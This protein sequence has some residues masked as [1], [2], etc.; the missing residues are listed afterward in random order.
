MRMN[1]LFS[2]QRFGWL[3]N[4]HTKE[5]YK[6][7]LISLAVMVAVL[8]LILIYMVPVNR[9]GGK[10]QDA[11][12]GFL[13]IG[14]GFIFTSSI[15]SEFRDGK[16][17]TSALTL[18]VSHL[19]RFAVAWLYSLVI[20]QLVYTVVFFVI[21]NIVG[22]YKISESEPTSMFWGNGGSYFSWYLYYSF[23]HSLAFLGAIVFKKWNY[24]KTTFIS[25]LFFATLIIFNKVV[26][27]MI[28][29]DS[30]SKSFLPFSKIT[31]ND[32]GSNIY[33]ISAKEWF[34]PIFIF[35][36][37]ICTVSLWAATYFKLKEKQV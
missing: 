28:F 14:V 15:F 27:G 34:T 8:T 2:L 4:K 7:Y 9:L 19:E 24:R 3:F 37:I 32:A 20:F 29:D 26:M 13:L 31:I 6:S 21:N 23:F 16:S 1:N 33:S 10:V 25:T 22:L 11:I 18:P 30:V 17:S 36:T 5:H 35:L 12:F